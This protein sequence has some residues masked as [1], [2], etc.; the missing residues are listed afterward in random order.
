MWTAIARDVVDI[1]N[2]FEDDPGITAARNSLIYKQD[3]KTLATDAGFK[4]M[5]V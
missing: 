5:A 2:L 1:L 4:V 3:R